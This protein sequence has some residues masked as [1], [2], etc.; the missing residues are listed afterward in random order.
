MLAAEP[1]PSVVDALNRG[2]WLRAPLIYALLQ[3]MLLIARAGLRLRV[4]G[5]AHLPARGPFIVTP[6]HQS[7]LDGFL[8]AG[9]LPFR[10]FRHVFFVGAAEYFQTPLAKAL[11]RAFN[12]V[13][14]DP[15]AHLVNAMRAAANGLRAG[16]ILMLFPEGERTI[17][18]RLRPFRKGAAILA[19]E[20][21]VPVIP[22]ALDGMQHVW[23]RGRGLAWRALRPWHRQPV[24]LDFGA[25]VFVTPDDYDGGT[26]SIQE[27]VARALRTSKSDARR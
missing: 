13:P 19:A 20:L 17:D 5:R 4:S 25:P 23:P 9:R 14:V 24:T 21:G 8:V 3:I 1:D 7:Y 10:H 26:A 18:G 2:A 27:A 12:I 16:K 15:D 11:A 6:N 22:T